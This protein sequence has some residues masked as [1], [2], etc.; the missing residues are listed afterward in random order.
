MLTLCEF[1]THLGPSLQ[2]EPIAPLTVRELR[3]AMV[4]MDPDALAALY[5]PLLRALVGH[6]PPVDLEDPVETP[7]VEF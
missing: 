1:F 3:D 7:V 4:T 2:P 6:P 5:V